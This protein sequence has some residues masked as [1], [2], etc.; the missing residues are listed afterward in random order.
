MM[1]VTGT[2]TFPLLVLVTSSSSGFA[3]LWSG[4]PFPCKESSVTVADMT[5]SDR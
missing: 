5:R 3:P 2:G 1:M 4:F